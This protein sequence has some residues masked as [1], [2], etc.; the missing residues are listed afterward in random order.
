[1]AYDWLRSNM[2][3]QANR[4][5]VRILYCAAKEGQT[6]TENAIRHLL[7]QDEELTAL[8]VQHQINEQSRI[9]LVTDVVVESNSL[10]SYDELLEEVVCHG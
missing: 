9:P 10:E 7:K 5:Y 8:N 1:M 3:L 6:V 4:Q 2:T